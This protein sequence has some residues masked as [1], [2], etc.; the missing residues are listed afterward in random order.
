M[1]LLRRPG[2]EVW[3]K[4]RPASG[5]WGGLWVPPEF[6]DAA[7]ARAHIVAETAAE[8]PPLRDLPLI[9]HAFTHFDLTIVPLL[10]EMPQAAGR[11]AEGD[12]V[13]YDPGA[14]KKLGLPAPVATLLVSLP[15][16]D[17]VGPGRMHDAA[18]S[19]ENAAWK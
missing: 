2:G 10:A 17:G 5:L 1:L 8:T 7:A 4:R 9:E 18:I 3:L 12:G 19:A 14:P 6:A 13:W 15:P 11:I 16:P